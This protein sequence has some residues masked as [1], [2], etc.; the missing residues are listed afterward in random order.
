MG[1]T[2]AFSTR[3]LVFLKPFGLQDTAK[4]LVVGSLCTFVLP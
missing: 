4:D 3:A 1:R 2:L